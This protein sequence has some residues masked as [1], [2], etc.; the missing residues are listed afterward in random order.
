MLGRPNA[1]SARHNSDKS[2]KIKSKLIR[3]H[4][5]CIFLIISHLE[6]AFY[7]I[8]YFDFTSNEVVYIKIQAS[9]AALYR[10]VIFILF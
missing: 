4:L 10:L 1:L 9:M 5:N 6:I 2:T 3:M 7:S 8:L